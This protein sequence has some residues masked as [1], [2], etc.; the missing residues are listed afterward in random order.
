MT[1]GLQAAAEAVPVK[2]EADARADE[3]ER[4]SRVENGNEQGRK[5]LEKADDDAQR[6]HE[7]HDEPPAG[8]EE[9]EGAVLLGL[10]ADAG[11]VFAEQP[12]ENEAEEEEEDQ[13]R[14]P[15][16]E[17]PGVRVLMEPCRQSD[18]KHLAAGESPHQSGGEEQG[19]SGYTVFHVSQDLVEAANIRQTA[20]RGS[21][22]KSI[23]FLS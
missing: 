14:L 18:G 7:R 12:V 21:Q 1:D 2:Q 11:G 4:K 23:S 10:P 5:Q 6:H 17:V 19:L 13:R 9:R 20:K 3:R 8:V 22:E 15:R 16:L